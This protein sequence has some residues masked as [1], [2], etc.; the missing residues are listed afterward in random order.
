[1]GTFGPNFVLVKSRI[2]AWLGYFNLGGIVEFTLL[3]TPQL[4]DQPRFALHI[5]ILLVG[6]D[7]VRVVDNLPRFKVE[8]IIF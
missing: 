8:V 7:A 6:D 5:H 4:V 3:L 2:Q 1:L